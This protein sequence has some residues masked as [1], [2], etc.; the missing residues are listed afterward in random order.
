MCVKP[1]GKHPGACVGLCWVEQ[2][3][4]LFGFSYPNYTDRDAYM[5]SELDLPV[6][7]LNA[8]LPLFTQYIS[9]WA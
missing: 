7:D 4:W 2:K 6:C 3:G 5:E 8:G 1:L 9:T